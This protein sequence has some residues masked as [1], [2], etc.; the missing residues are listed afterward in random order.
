[1]NFCQLKNNCQFYK[2]QHDGDFL[3]TISH[4]FSAAFK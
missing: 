3:D 4:K 1:L 2:D